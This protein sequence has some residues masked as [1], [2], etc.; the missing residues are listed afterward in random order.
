MSSREAA[1][2]L[3]HR[4]Q[5]VDELCSKGAYKHP[6]T[7]FRGPDHSLRPFGYPQLSQRRRLTPASREVGKV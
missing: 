2:R 1:R 5:D 6:G 3:F 7:D 4:Q